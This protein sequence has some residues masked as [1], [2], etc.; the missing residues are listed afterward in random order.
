MNDMQKFFKV[1]MVKK[2]SNHNNLRTNEIEG[3]SNKLPF[4]GENFILLS[5]GLEQGVRVVRTTSVTELEGNTFKTL[6]S[7]YIFDVLEENIEASV[8]ENYLYNLSDPS[9]N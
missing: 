6:N 3:F 8:V 7:I 2:E 9:V 5:K 1:K 4:V